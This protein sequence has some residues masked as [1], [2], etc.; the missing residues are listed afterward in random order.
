MAGEITSSWGG[1]ELLQVIG[2]G[3]WL[4][5]RGH[6]PRSMFAKRWREGEREGSG[7]SPVDEMPP[8]S[9][10]FAVYSLHVKVGLTA[11]FPRPPSL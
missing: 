2:L 9:R 1:T 7:K 10:F 6:G 11:A 5:H 4:H 8:A 3:P